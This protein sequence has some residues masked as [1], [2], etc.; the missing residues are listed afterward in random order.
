[1]YMTRYDSYITLTLI[2]YLLTWPLKSKICI[3][4]GADSTQDDSGKKN[5]SVN[6]NPKLDHEL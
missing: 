1:M 5:D 2:P 6:Y 3:R 4:Y